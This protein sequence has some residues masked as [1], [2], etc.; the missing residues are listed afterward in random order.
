MQPKKELVCIYLFLIISTMINVFIIVEG[1]IGGSDSASQ[2]FSIT[3]LFI[4]FVKLFDPNSPIVTDPVTTH[5]V[6]RKLVGHYGLFGL[7]GLFTTLTLIFIND[8]MSLHKK[9]ILIIS[10]FCGVSLAFLSEL[11]QLLTP[12]RYMSVIDMLID[13]AGYISF[14]GIAFLIAYLSYR[15]KMKKQA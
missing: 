5:A 12:G 13:L 1:F 6:M 3:N 7:S 11:A 14:G 10:L 4:E 15:K 8:G 9:E 2:S